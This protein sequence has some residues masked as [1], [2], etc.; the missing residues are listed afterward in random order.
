[1]IT[2]IYLTFTAQR[3]FS[4][5][6]CNESGSMDLLTGQYLDYFPDR[7]SIAF[8]YC[9]EELNVLAER[10]PNERKGIRRFFAPKY[11]DGKVSAKNREV[12]TFHLVRFGKAPFLTFYNQSPKFTVVVDKKYRSNLVSPLTVE[13]IPGVSGIFNEARYDFPEKN[14]LCL[15]KEFVKCGRMIGRYFRCDAEVKCDVKLAELAVAVIC[16]LVIIPEFMPNEAV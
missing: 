7:Y 15:P 4:I 16:G 9:D 10:S 11:L 5:L 1:M 12:A 13:G 6:L 3:K 2:D 14:S 8:K